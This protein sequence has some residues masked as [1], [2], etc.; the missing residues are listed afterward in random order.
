MEKSQLFKPGKRRTFLPQFPSV[1]GAGNWNASFVQE[2]CSVAGGNIVYIANHKAMVDVE[3]R[4][5]SHIF[6]SFC[7]TVR[8]IDF[9][10][11]IVDRFRPR[12]IG[13]QTQSL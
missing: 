12:I 1:N 9:S 5:A 4:G 7:G 11:R 3:I 13:K 8:E 10:A 6:T 2:L